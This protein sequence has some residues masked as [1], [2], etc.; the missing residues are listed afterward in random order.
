MAIRFHKRFK[1][2]PG[3]TLNL[4][5]KSVSVRAGPKNAGITIGTKGSTASASVPETG[6]SV[7]KKLTKTRKKP[8]AS[9]HPEMDR[10]GKLSGIGCLV[11]LAIIIGVPLLMLL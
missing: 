10:F 11:M 7:Q 8:E 3:L 2:A 6:L 1:I 4:N 5:K 9:A